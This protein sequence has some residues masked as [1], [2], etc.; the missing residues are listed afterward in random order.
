MSLGVVL[1]ED[2]PPAVAELTR[3]IETWPGGARVIG[4]AHA[5]KGGIELLQ[6]THPD[7][8]FADIRLSDGLS[9]R[10]FEAL[11]PTAPVIFATA[12]DEHVIRAMAEN[13]IDYLLKPIEAV[14]VWQA[15]DKYV[16]LG[17]HYGGR[18]LDLARTLR[19]AP[20]PPAR[21]LA[22]KG[23]AIVA[24]P[25]SEIAW[26][27]SEHKL[28]LLIPKAGPRLMVDEPLGALAAR[29]GPRFFRA[30]RQF[31]LSAD[32]VA[33]FRPAGKGRLAVTLRPPAEDDVVISQP[34]AAPFRAWLAG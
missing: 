19:G 20:A 26:F 3:A 6:Q 23:A 16:R 33:A 24:V 14:R 21:V 32:A 10:V 9:F 15:L 12:Y 1:L 27:T 29:L 28:T 13:A 17:R 18:V 2:E 7:V 8:I 5:V 4:T 30:S 34:L 22:R 25:T 31:L 11:P